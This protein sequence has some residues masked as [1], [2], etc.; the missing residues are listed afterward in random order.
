[1]ETEH[2][3]PNIQFQKHDFFTPQ[4]AKGADVYIYRWIFHN[5]G[6]DE[7][8]KILQA[9]I[10]ALKSGAKILINDGCLPVPGTGHLSEEKASRYASSL[11]MCLDVVAD[12]DR[13]LDICMMV[14]MNA[15]EREEGDWEALFKKADARFKY[16]GARRPKGSRMSLIEAEW[17]GE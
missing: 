6:D 3:R 1:M 13:N 8:V 5:W 16:L 14:A 7:S 2:K 10:P 9:A 11:C 12:L 4:I 15:K 17:T